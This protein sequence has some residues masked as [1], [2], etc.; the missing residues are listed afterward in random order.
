M[1]YVVFG[2]IGLGM[3]FTVARLIMGPHLSDRIVSLDTFNMMVI[4]IVVLLALFFKNNLY[5]DIALIY[6]LLAFLESIVFARYME[7]KTHDYS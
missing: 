5:L 1:I 2:L 4:G 3:I 7:G 6:G